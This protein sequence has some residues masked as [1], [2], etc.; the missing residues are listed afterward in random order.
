MK[1]QGGLEPKIAASSS[2]IT[3]ALVVLTA[4][5]IGLN[6]TVMKWALDHTT[7]LALAA[8]RTSVGAPFL[9]AI[10]M[11][12]GEK[13]PQNRQQWMAVWWI[14]L[15]ITTVSSGFLVLGISRLSPGLAAMLSA[16]MP[17]FTAIIAVIV[18]TELPGRRGY[19]G[20]LIGLFGAVC[21]AIPAFGSGNTT[22]G[23]VFS[24][25]SSISWAAGAVLNK[26]LP[27]ALEISPLMLVALKITFSAI[28]LHLAVPFVEDWSD[29]SMGWG[30]ALPLLY[31]GIPSLAVTFYLFASVLR[32][33]PAIQGAA[34]AYLTPFFGVLFSWL[35]VGDR[36]GTFEMLGGALVV[37]GVALLSVDRR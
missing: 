10:A 27:G 4:L 24:L 23:I 16:T 36:L 17:L 8:L 30:L 21:L 20:L 11:L 5:L 1:K 18:L 13:L 34:V 15:A 22:L 25:I 31:A 9:L 37:T 6:Y 3:V 26:R 12:R 14:S 35:L 32:R 28:C 7:P 29:T 2:S 33:A 19:F